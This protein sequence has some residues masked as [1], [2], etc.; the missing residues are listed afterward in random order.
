L[1]IKYNC[2]LYTVK[3][4]H[5]WDKCVHAFFKHKSRRLVN[6]MWLLF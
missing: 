1:N 5:V 4:I 3:I 6:T 2:D